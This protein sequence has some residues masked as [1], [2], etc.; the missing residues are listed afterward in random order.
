[1]FVDTH[2]HQVF[3]SNDARQTLGELLADARTAGLAGICITDHFDKDVSY[4]PGVE[5]VFD[6]D[7]YFQQLEPVR[8]ATSGETTRLLIGIE[9]GWMPHLSDYLQ[10]I[11]SNRPFDSIILSLHFLDGQ[12]IYLEPGVFSAGV[13]PAYRRSLERTLTM[14]E[15]F[16]DFTILGHF[17]Y[18]S[19]YAP[20]HQRLQYNHAPAA[21]DA[22]FRYLAAH[23][24]CLEINT[25]TT[26]KR[27]QQGLAADLTWPDPQIIRR[28]LELGGKHISLGADSHQKGQAGLLFA[29]AAAYLKNQGVT[30]L[31]H[32]ENRQP[33]LMKL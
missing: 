31:T 2:S 23:G 20:D 33:I 19:R 8:K 32:Y 9:L 5:D 24:K 3:F 10:V 18:I 27:Q 30:H 28:Y 21:F 1:M 12:D 4:E 13:V 25:R 6:L 7:D 26:L 15:G 16:P 14:M 17:D 29:E 22:I 11:T